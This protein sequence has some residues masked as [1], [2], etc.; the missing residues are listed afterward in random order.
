MDIWELPTSLNI[1][2]TDYKIRSDFRAILD[3]LK[4]FSDPNYDNY[5]KWEIG[6]PNF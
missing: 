2:G 6:F 1:A 5:E 3:I 4:Y